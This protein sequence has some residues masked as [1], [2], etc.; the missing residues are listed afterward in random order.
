MSNCTLSIDFT[1]LCTTCG[2]E[3][4]TS[5]KTNR[6]NERE[7]HVEVCP[8]CSKAAYA[9]GVADEKARPSATA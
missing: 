4:D 5:E 8:D 7:L 2:T 3:L 6:R 1:V 9:D